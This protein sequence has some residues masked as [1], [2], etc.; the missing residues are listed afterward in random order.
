MRWNWG[1]HV[2]TAPALVKGRDGAQAVA[3]GIDMSL[4]LKIDGTV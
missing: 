1:G 4:V 2:R 3:A